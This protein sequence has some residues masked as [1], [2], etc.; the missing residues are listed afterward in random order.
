MAP[1]VRPLLQSV[2]LDVVMSSPI[3]YEA[4]FAIDAE[5]EGELTEIGDA[6]SRVTAELTDGERSLSFDLQV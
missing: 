6:T 5:L 3:E 4:S 1:Q 2:R